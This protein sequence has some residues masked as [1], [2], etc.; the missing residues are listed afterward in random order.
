MLVTRI[1]VREMNEKK[2]QIQIEDT[3]NSTAKEFMTLLSS[4]LDTDTRDQ[5]WGGRKG[6]K[7]KR[8]T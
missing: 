2:K 6:D 7:F 4:G 1:E 8:K 5:G 3:S